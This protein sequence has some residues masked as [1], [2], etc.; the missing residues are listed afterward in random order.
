MRSQIFRKVSRTDDLADVSA[1]AGAEAGAGA[2]K[3]QGNK[4]RSQTSRS[5]AGVGWRR[6][7]AHTFG[8]EDESSKRQLKK[9][10]FEQNASFLCID[11]RGKAATQGIRFFCSLIFSELPRA[12]DLRSCRLRRGLTLVPCLRIIAQKFNFVAKLSYQPPQA[13][14]ADMSGAH[15]VAFLIAA[16]PRE[17]IFFR[18]L[19]IARFCGIIQEVRRSDRNHFNRSLIPR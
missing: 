12:R 1:P 9:S 2:S 15:N 16:S 19:T 13:F 3:L 6:Q 11:A 14:M 17:F 4:S 7:I 10:N 8:V 18:L 5:F